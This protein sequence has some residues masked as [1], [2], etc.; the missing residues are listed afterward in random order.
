MIKVLRSIFTDRDIMRLFKTRYNAV[1][2]TM[3]HR[4]RLRTA[5]IHELKKQIAQSLSFVQGLSKHLFQKLLLPVIF[6]AFVLE[7]L[8]R[9]Q[10]QDIVHKKKTSL[11]VFRMARRRAIAH[12]RV[13]TF[14]FFNNQD[15]NIE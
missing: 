13:D 2:V 1:A 4:C 5:D 6:L 12:Q 3:T 7:L 11:S 8:F 14:F 10:F 9:F 15:Y